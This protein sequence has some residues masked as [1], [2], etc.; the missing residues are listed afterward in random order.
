MPA[1][2]QLIPARPGYKAVFV[3]IETGKPEFRDV[4]VWGLI[5]EE[6]EPVACDC[7]DCQ[8]QEAMEI[9]QGVVPLIVSPERRGYT[10]QPAFL[11]DGCLG[12]ADPN[13]TLV[14]WS[15]RA[16]EYLA[17]KAAGM[18]EEQQV[19]KPTWN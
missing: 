8:G 3:N 1:I 17:M 11:F 12:V 4:V 7:P 6:G 19:E 15:A 9:S 14:A 10:L 13:D 16:S 2:V 5:E 18:L